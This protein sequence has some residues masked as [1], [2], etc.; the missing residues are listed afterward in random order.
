MNV[1]LGGSLLKIGKWWHY[2]VPPLLAFAYYLL[3]T[4]H[5]PIAAGTAALNLL[6]FLVAIL[7]VAGFGHVVNDLCDLEQDRRA[8]K[9]NAMQRLT[10]FQRLAVVLLLLLLSGLPWLF[11]PHHWTN[12]GLVGLQ[13]A[14]L[15]AYSLP[16]IRLKERGLLGVVADALYGFTVPLLITLTTFGQLG[17]TWP[18]HNSPAPWLLLVA[19]SFLCG[20]RSILYHQA[21]DIAN[22]RSAGVTTFAT[23]HGSETVLR[24]ISRAVIPMEIACFLAI[25]TVFSLDLHLFL[26]GFLLYVLWRTF[27][28]RYMWEESLHPIRNLT[29]SRFIRLYGYVYLGEFYE[30]WLPMFMLAALVL[31]APMYALLAI[32]HILLFKNGVSEFILKDLRHI[33]GGIAKMK[34]ELLRRARGDRH[35]LLEPNQL[36]A[37]TCQNSFVYAV[38]G[39]EKHLRTL[40][41][42]LSYLRSRTRNR[43]IVVT[44]TRRNLRSIRHDAIIDVKTPAELDDHQAS[45]YLKTR[46]PRLL[47]LRHNYCYLDSDVLAVGAGVDTI[48]EHA[49][50]PV[51]FA[52]D[53][54]IMENNVNR[55]SPWALNCA[56]TG[57]GDTSSCT[58]L[59]E[60]IERKY[61]ISVPGDWV[62]WNG[63]VFLFGRDSIR[64][65]DTWHELTMEIFSD[66]YWKTRDQATLI[67]TA[68]KLGVQ[69]QKC[70]PHQYNFI[71]DLGNYDL[72]FHKK[73]GY[74]L[75]ESL[76]P[77]HPCFLHLYSSEL[78]CE[79][80]SMTHDLE[81]AILEKMRR[82]R[83]QEHR[84]TAHLPPPIR[85]IGRTAKRVLKQLLT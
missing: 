65:M 75:H 85:M 80:W 74:A 16:P 64:F 67:V 58:H 30:R 63:G 42:S 43:I 34:R 22:D 26:P 17:A 62:H 83:K 25:S 7:G 31:R 69:D 27:Q 33:P 47:D 48:F 45:I 38:C 18:P 14:L 24:I 2:K 8:G 49:Y 78:E 37:M 9:D 12:L 46:L 66:P 77:I 70:L 61:G 76:P 68:W 36:T 29:T 20:T 41:L 3:A 55:F 50:G 82:R 11:L 23:R 81:N 57:M 4:R 15:V 40:E 52:Q 54:P 5:T 28:V 10:A 39:P 53:L 32:G 21:S 72:C 1:S 6:A 56:C 73:H 84:W 19:W 44:D 71:A 60:A 35:E 51:T 13:V 79:G 59:V